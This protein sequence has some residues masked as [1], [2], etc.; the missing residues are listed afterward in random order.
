[1]N[2]ATAAANVGINHLRSF[3]LSAGRKNARICHKIMGEHATKD[4]QNETLKRTLNYSNGSIAVSTA[5]PCASV[6]RNSAIGITR[7]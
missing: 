2:R 7:N 4:T 5:M 6:G 1:M 3:G